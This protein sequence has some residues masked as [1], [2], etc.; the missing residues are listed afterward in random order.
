MLSFDFLF[1]CKLLETSTSYICLK[2]TLIMF[3][4]T[5]VLKNTTRFKYIFLN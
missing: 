5:S 2:K 4:I 1:L 3:L